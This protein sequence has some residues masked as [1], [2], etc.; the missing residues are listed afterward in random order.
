M[1]TYN[2]VIENVRRQLQ[3]IPPYQVKLTAGYTAGSGTM[4]VSATD[5]VLN[6]I[7][8]GA[9]IGAGLNVLQVTSVPSAGAFSVVGGVNGS[10]DA[11]QG[12]G[13]LVEVNPRFQR[14]DIAQEINRELLSLD[15]PTSGLGQIRTVQAT[16]I[17]VF[18]AYDLGANFDQERSKVL[19][20]N[21]KI[22]PPFRT[23]PLI[24]RGEYRVIRHADT[25]V[26]PNG[27][28]L[29]I[30]MNRG[31]PWPG[32]PI[33][34]YFLAPFAPLVNLTDDLLTVGGVPLNM[35]DIVEMGTRLRLAPDREIARNAMDA[36]PDPRKAPE[37]PP[38]AMQQAANS[39]AARYMRRK[40]EESGRIRRAYPN[41]EG[42]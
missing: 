11:N 23:Y 39:L 10:T 12:N 7:Q 16:Y 1:S 35:Q 38:N 25:G 17:P 2:D 31:T 21:F 3:P 33:T 15:A 18:Q 26:F 9:L 28:A 36:Q 32:F 20:V 42:W 13:T 5:P 19:E 14:F 40:N 29:R 22:A 8:P 30:Q 4:Q 27:V 6:A 37:V 41:A 24:R 34:V